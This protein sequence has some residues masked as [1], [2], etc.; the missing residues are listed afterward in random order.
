MSEESHTA[1]RDADSELSIEDRLNLETA[2][3]GWQE[4]QRHFAR[5]VVIVVAGQLDLIDIAAAFI[6][7]DRRRVEMLMERGQIRRAVDED[8]VA[9]NAKETEFWCVAVAPWVL[10]Q[11]N[12]AGD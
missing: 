5:G 4:L 9:W 12:S 10:I 11:E 2:R 3:I 6:R 7:D 8:A 1:S